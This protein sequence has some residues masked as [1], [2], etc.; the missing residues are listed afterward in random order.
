[1]SA[2]GLVDVETVAVLR[3]RWLAGTLTDRR[4]P[5]AVADLQDLDVDRYPVLPFT[6]RA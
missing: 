5:A 6:R 1:M 3:K 2:P 4:L